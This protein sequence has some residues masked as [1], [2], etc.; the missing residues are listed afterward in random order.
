MNLEQ[1]SSPLP[2]PWLEISADKITCRELVVSGGSV[3]GAFSSYQAGSLNLLGVPYT[4]VAQ[5]PTITNPAYN[6]STNIYT[7]PAAQTLSFTMSYVMGWP[8]ASTDI[9]TAVSIR[10]NGVDTTFI[11]GCKS[12][13]GASATNGISISGIIQLQAGDTLGYFITNA[14]GAGGTLFYGCFSGFVL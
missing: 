5:V 1:L 9:V 14:G 7:A 12:L 2:K 6:P 13:Q 11:S 8:V 10:K 4:A 3:G